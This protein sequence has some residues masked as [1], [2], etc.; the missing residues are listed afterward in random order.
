M[1]FHRN[2]TP[3]ITV[4]LFGW[5]RLLLLVVKGST[6]HGFSVAST[7]TTSHANTEWQIRRGNKKAG[8]WVPCDAMFGSNKHHAA[9]TLTLAGSSS[10]GEGRTRTANN[11]G[12]RPTTLPYSDDCFG[13]VF[14]LSLLLAGDV[15]FAACFAL[16]SA[17][18][19][20]RVNVQKQVRFTK[21]LPSVV[22]VWTLLIVA[23]VTRVIL[24]H[25]LLLDQMPSR[26]PHA[27]TIEVALVAVSVLYGWWVSS[28][29]EL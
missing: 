20:Y 15:L 17:G 10:S 21:Q 27:T 4:L 16:V 8:V 23:P 18:A 14:L 7:M 29:P 19:A 12:S 6:V 24:G 3:L 22:A 11:N 13:F 2:S 5:L 1:V 25:W 26:L 28:R 9:T